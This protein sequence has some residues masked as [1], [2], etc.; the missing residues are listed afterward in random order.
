LGRFPGFN[1]PFWVDGFCVVSGI[2]TV[3]LGVQPERPTDT[4]ASAPVLQHYVG[5]SENQLVD[6]AV[7][8]LFALEENGQRVPGSVN[9]I[10]F[11]GPPGTG[12]SLLVAG[13]GA[14]WQ[15]QY[16]SAKVVCRTGIDLCRQLTESIQANGVDEFRADMESADLLVVDDAQMVA[17][18]SPGED[19]LCCLLDSRAESG[20]PAIFALDQ[21]PATHAQLSQ[22]LASRLL[23][24]LSV[25]LSPPGD[26][27]RQL[28]L[29]QLA[30]GARISVSADACRLITCSA[31]GKDVFRTP[32]QL[33]QLIQW[34]LSRGHDSLDDH[35]AQLAISHFDQARRPSMKLISL[36]VSRQ[37][38]I[39]VSQLRGAVR[40]RYIVRARGVAMLLCRRHS[41][42]S[43]SDIGRF[44][45]K[46][47]H[48]TVIHACRRTETLAGGDPVLRR[49]VDQLG[50]QFSELLA[51]EG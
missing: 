29:E 36:V 18:R 26:G 25:P 41:G 33:R 17:G 51:T 2:F 22:R 44:F 39:P 40:K 38:N 42:K 31:P 1:L 8:T 43:F 4:T 16:P 5:S 9:P 15:A 45:G 20:R 32:L 27:A 14:R 19:F 49:V 11:F 48:S 7:T 35:S 28:I 24:G 37:F 13:I 12:K 47:D 10:V 6:V 3:P 23:S 50:R 46:R 21:S 34:L 30:D